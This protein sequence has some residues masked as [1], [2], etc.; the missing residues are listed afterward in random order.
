MLAEYMR[1]RKDGCKTEISREAA[2]VVLKNGYVEKEIDHNTKTLEAGVKFLDDIIKLKLEDRGQIVS[3]EEKTFRPLPSGIEYE[4]IIDLLIRTDDGLLIVDYK[5]KSLL[6]SSYFLH[7]PLNR[8]MRGYAWVSGA[9]E[10]SIIILHC[11]KSPQAYE[12]NFRYE[13]GEIDTW[14]IETDH[15]ADRIC[16]WINR[17]KAGEYKGHY[18]FPRAATKC[19]QFGCEYFKLCIQGNYETAVIDPSDYKPREER[20]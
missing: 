1:W 8:Q 3:V 18:L 2:I 17:V 11:V 19:Q 15:T 6:P 9:D 16:T 13:P 20:R 10:C 14:L 4:A 7:F 12:H 5:T